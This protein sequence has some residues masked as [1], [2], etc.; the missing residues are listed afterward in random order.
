M[1]QSVL[2]YYDLN[3]D[4]WLGITHSIADTNQRLEWC[5]VREGEYIVIDSNGWVYMAQEDEDSLWGYHWQRTQIQNID[6]KMIVLKY[7]HGEQLS[8]AELSFIR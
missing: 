1:A 4:G 7:A 5:D 6:F 2:K 8:V 3:R